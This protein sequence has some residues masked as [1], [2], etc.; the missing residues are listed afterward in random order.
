MHRVALSLTVFFLASSAARA[1]AETESSKAQC[2][3]A[4]AQGQRDRKA[5]A[6]GRAKE[7]FAFCGSSAC[8]G[9]LHPDCV[10][11]LGEVEA[12]QPEVTF[13]ISSPAGDEIDGVS[14]AIDGGARQTLE[15]R[16]LTFDPGEHVV[17]VERSGYHPEERRFAISE[18]KKLTLT[19]VL[20]PLSEATSSRAVSARES[21]EPPGM[22]EG[23]EERRATL[24][25][26]FVGVGVG[27][28]GAAGFAYFGLRAR[29]GDRALGDCAPGCSERDV[30]RVKRDYLFANVSLGVGAAGL[31]GA[32]AWAIFRPREPAGTSAPMARKTLELRLGPICSVTGHF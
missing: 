26:T 10:R 32:G 9:A 11:W 18:G 15:G 24:L 19:L 6:L 29:D 4:Y 30:D 31:L 7:A 21:S 28:V 25:P 16:E 27:V 22:D 3:D 20:D 8:P 1:R 17:L 5:G 23:G 14:I 13:E 2:L 12:A